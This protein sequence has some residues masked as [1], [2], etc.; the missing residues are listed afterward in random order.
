MSAR[1]ARFSSRS[2][3]SSFQRAEDEAVH[4]NCPGCGATLSSPLPMPDSLN[5]HRRALERLFSAPD[6]QLT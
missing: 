5:E 4:W 3:R 1:C 2:A 6:A